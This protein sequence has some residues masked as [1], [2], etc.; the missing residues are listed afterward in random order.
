MGSWNKQDLIINEKHHFE[1]VF[2][3]LNQVMDTKINLSLFFPS[4]LKKKFKNTSTALVQEW[5]S[6][7]RM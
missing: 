7:T 4:F 5:N 2:E 1:R 6:P 3:V